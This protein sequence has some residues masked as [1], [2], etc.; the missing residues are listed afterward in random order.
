MIDLKQWAVWWVTGSQHLYGPEA[1]AEVAARGLAAAIPVTVQFKSVVTTPESILVACQVAKA[2]TRCVR[3]LAWMHTFSLAK[4]WIAGLTA[5]QR[6]LL[7]LHTQF[8][9]DIP[10]STIDMDYM[11]LHQSN[12]G[13]CE[14][15]YSARAWGCAAR[16]Q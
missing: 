7:H 3:V 4:M 10:W 12:H 5:L 8:Q 14:F 1:D 2:A 11:N 13:D 16:G 9:R 6:P 15:G